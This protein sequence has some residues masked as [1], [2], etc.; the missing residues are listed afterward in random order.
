MPKEDIFGTLSPDAELLLISDQI[1]NNKYSAQT[2][3]APAP[4]RN[5]LHEIENLQLFPDPPKRGKNEIFNR[6]YYYYNTELPKPVPESPVE[7]FLRNVNVL[8]NAPRLE[9][10]MFVYITEPME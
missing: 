6:D 1:L 4:I 8:K 9:L 2:I 10:R 3:R 7:F 5:V